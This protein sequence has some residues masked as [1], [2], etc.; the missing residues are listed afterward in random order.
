MNVPNDLWSLRLRSPILSSV[1]RRQVSYESPGLLLPV[2]AGPATP[3]HRPMGPCNNHSSPQCLPVPSAAHSAA[4]TAS[5]TR[6][7]T[8][9]S[10]LC[11]RTSRSGGD[12][13]ARCLLVTHPLGWELRLMATDLLG[14]QVCRSTDDILRTHEQWD[15]PSSSNGWTRLAASAG[16][17]RARPALCCR[18]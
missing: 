15:A 4:S 9:A 13:I 12:K 18:R 6:L 7:T 5:V 17:G 11:G 2:R 14:S 16:L 8:S 3:P 10:P 1:V